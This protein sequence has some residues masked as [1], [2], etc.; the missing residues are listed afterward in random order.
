TPTA[1][2]A[3]TTLT[4]VATPT[5]TA[6]LAATST[7][8]P[9]PTIAPSTPTETATPTATP[10]PPATPTVTPTATPSDP[11]LVLTDGGLVRGVTGPGVRRFLGIPYAAAPVGDR[12]WRSPM[13][14]EPWTDVRDATQ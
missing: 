4:A 3:T 10:P 1:A 2:G 7:R 8:A 11:L 12:R 6:R 13:R 5:A 14:R 9:T